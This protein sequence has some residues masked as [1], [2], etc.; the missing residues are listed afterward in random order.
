MWRIG[1]GLVAGSCAVLCLP[2]LP[3]PAVIGLAGAAGALL[4]AVMRQPWIAAV[5]L[6]CLLTSLQLQRSLGDRLDPSL[7]NQSI[8]VSGTVASV[9]QGSV[10]LLRFRF[11]PDDEHLPRLVDLTWYD[12]PAR[13]LAGERLRL[14]VKLRRPRGFANPGRS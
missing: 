11:A 8:D 14:Q 3:A 10:E 9:P 13:V 1:A 12:A 7:Q 6:G 2:Q 5:A 4:A